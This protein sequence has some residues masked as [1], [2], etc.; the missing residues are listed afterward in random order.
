MATFDDNWV[1]I[2]ADQLRVGHYVKINHS[3]FD[4]PFVRRIFPITS[5]EEVAII[6]N[7]RL[8]KLYVDHGRSTPASSSDSPQRPPGEEQRVA[9]LVAELKA[10]K[11][12]QLDRIQ[13]HRAALE[14]TREIYSET[15]NNTAELLGMLEAGD[16]G[17][18]KQLGL[19]VGQVV[20]TVINGQSPL[21]LVALDTPVDGPQRIALLATDAVGICGVLGRRM[22]LDPQEMMALTTAAAVHGCGLQRLPALLM[23]ESPEGMQRASSVFQLYPTRSVEILKACGGFTQTVQR[24]VQEHRERPDGSGFPH[25]LAGDAI[26]PL[27]LLLGAVREFQVQCRAPDAEPTA[28]LAWLYR[29]LRPVY[30]AQIIDQL[31]SSTTVYPPGT[32]V[33]LSDGSMA[34][35]L[36]VNEADRMRPV[37]GILDEEGGE[38]EMQILDLLQEPQLAIRS[39][40]QRPRVPPAWLDARKRSWYGMGL[41]PPQSIR[42]GAQAM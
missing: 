29:E 22:G 30:G 18:V 41:A 24:I 19:W 7:G 32:F 25:G 9:E 27:A 33:E 28:A 5:E 21:A 8:T 38:R 13:E 14:A 2:R 10:E 34:R 26:H 4:H 36:R 11:N 16:S 15:V 31:V 20:E 37:V 3:W 42:V 17:S 1:P 6:R 39:L 12:A 40:A 35:V 23:D